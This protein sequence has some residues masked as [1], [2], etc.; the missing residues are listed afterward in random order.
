MPRRVCGF[1]GGADVSKE[2]VFPKWIGRLLDTN[3]RY[4]VAFVRPQRAKDWVQLDIGIQVHM[5]CKR[6]NS[7]W[8]SDLERRVQ[9]ILTPMMT[10]GGR[11]PL[12]IDDQTLVAGWISKTVMVLEYAGE[13]EPF[14]TADERRLM[15]EAQI[16]PDRT[17]IWA[18]R[19]LGRVRGHWS[20]LG[21]GFQVSDGRTIPGKC[22]TFSLGQV[23]VQMFSYRSRKGPAVQLNE[24]PM[25][26][27]PWDT[28]L[29]SLWPVLTNGLEWPPTHHFNDEGL[30]RLEARLTQR[31][32]LLWR[33]RRGK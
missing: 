2:H 19:Y 29:H 26:T 6:C 25:A 9:P 8:M 13:D 31:P 16:P 11:M 17:W 10:S 24:V 33:V 7:G 20:V 12:D 18:G 28:S 1:C 21:L 30:A 32:P 23:A 15:M 3:D 27:G 22:T 5:P 4:R 14:Y